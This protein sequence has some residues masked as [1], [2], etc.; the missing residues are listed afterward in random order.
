L[1]SVL[2]YANAQPRAEV[3]PEAAAVTQPQTDSPQ[4]ADEVVVRGRRMDE[5]EFDLNDYA[6]QFIRAV[7]TPPSGQ[8]YARWHRRVCVG[9]HN[10]ERSAAQYIVDRVSRLAVDVGLTPGEPGCRPDVIVIFTL[11]G[12]TVATYMVESQMRTFQ[13][14]MGLGGM[15]RG[16]EALEEF[17]QS[18][19]A[20][21]WWHVSFPVDAR[22]GNRAVRMQQ[23]EVP[24][25]VS[26]AG[27][28]RIH[29]GIR[30]D[31]SHVIVIVDTTKLA[32][33]TWEQLGDYLAVVS[34][35]QI[36]PKANLS[37]FDSILNLFENPRAYSGLTDWDRSFV[38][39]LYE[40][41][42]ELRPELQVG[43]LANEMT[44]HEL[45]RE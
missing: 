16:D 36:D 22:T 9:V 41:D 26:V 10:L 40:F 17:M 42:Q 34:L 27:P 30:D 1:S 8:G 12:D 44:E 11:D 7:A 5:I 33:T 21:R 13:P 14:G 4:P 6:T 19:S 2:A 18:D 28:S 32:G 20:V 15:A 43:E 38:R 29:N 45:D 3:A 25:A 23:D 24:P 37:D 31:L 35:A 39:A